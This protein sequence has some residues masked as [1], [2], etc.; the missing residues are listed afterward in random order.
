MVECDDIPEDPDLA[1]ST[2]EREV[3]TEGAWATLLGLDERSTINQLVR[4]LCR[5]LELPVP[6]SRPGRTLLL[7]AVARAVR[8]S[9]IRSLLD[10]NILVEVLQEIVPS[11]NRGRAT[12]VLDLYRGEIPEDGTLSGDMADDLVEA[13]VVRMAAEFGNLLR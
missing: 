1:E 9:E 7:G 6:V 5:L 12:I 4:A 3:R 2:G 10:E 11:G 13:L 8:A